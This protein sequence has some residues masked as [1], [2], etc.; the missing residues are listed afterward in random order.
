MWGEA[1]PAFRTR[2]S[3]RDANLRCWCCLR[4]TRTP[5]LSSADAVDVT[6]PPAGGGGAEASELIEEEAEAPIPTDIVADYNRIRVSELKPITE[7]LLEQRKQV[8]W[9][10]K[11][12]ETRYVEEVSAGAGRSRRRGIQEPRSR[13]TR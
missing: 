10:A 7:D 12:V 1:V 4:Q 9:M 5:A 6:A 8:S 2:W 11:Q 3:R 13:V